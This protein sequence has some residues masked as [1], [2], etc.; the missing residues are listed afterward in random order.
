MA[1]AIYILSC[2]DNKSNQ[3]RLTLL[4]E[5]VKTEGIKYKIFSEITDKNGNQSLKN[6]LLSRV[7]KKE[8]DT[9]LVYKL[10]EWAGSPAQLSM[11]L[12]ELN[13]KGIRFISSFENFDS[14]SI[15]GKFY[16]QILL[17]VNKCEKSSDSYAKDNL[18][19]DLNSD[20]Q[21]FPVH[22]RTASRTSEEGPTDLGYSGKK[23]ILRS[24]DNS[25]NNLTSGLTPAKRKSPAPSDN[26]DLVGL[27]EACSLTGYS[28]HTIYQ[29]TSKKLI[30]HFKRPHGRRIFFSKIA[31]E[32]WILTG[33]V[34]K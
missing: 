1:T 24:K 19:S 16:I 12:N 9:I 11:E 21:R 7:Y 2:D 27:D 29:L 34:K 26:F 10:S 33:E 13:E 28:R 20:G 18:R 3:D 5:R 30:P 14:F 31:L 15:T 8:F 17:T 25:D 23:I 6:E 4:V 32:Q 22:N